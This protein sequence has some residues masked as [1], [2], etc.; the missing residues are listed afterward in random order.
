M[1]NDKT[2]TN[3]NRF[4]DRL[5]N[6]VEKRNDKYLK[7]LDSANYDTRTG[8]RLFSPKIN[9]YKPAKHTTITNINTQPNKVT[10]GSENEVK[11]DFI[12][13]QENTVIVINKDT[14][15]N[16]QVNL[17]SEF[18]TVQT[19]TNTILNTQTNTQVNYKHNKQD[20]KHDF[21]KTDFKTDNKKTDFKTENKTDN[22]TVNRFTTLSSTWKI[23]KERQNKLKSEQEK[24]QLKKCNEKKISKTSEDLTK[25]VHKKIFTTLF[26]QLDY[27]NKNN[28]GGSIDLNLVDLPTNIK[29]IISPLLEELAEEGESLT[30]EEFVLACDDLY[31]V[32][33]YNI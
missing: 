10:V 30:L 9:K 31:K 22:K 17:K 23:T 21:K 27:E 8:V 5:Q 13:I 29:D 33:N 28:I 19:L 1:I 32:N 11:F 15:T 6:W 24:E 4:Y 14:V 7:E 18:K 25:E 2:P 26:K 16:T 3:I 12:I 20:S